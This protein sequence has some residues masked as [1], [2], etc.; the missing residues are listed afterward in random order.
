MEWFEVMKQITNAKYVMLA[1]I[2]ASLYGLSSPASKLLLEKLSPTVMASML[3]LGA[4]VGM[5]ILKII[6]RL[7]KFQNIEASLSKKEMPYI[8]GMI[9]LDILA[10]IFLMIGLTKTT[11]SNASLLNNFEI[12]VT[13]M[14][15][16]FVFKEAV[17]KRMWI[18][19]F[20]ITLSSV[21]LTFED[22]SSFTFS[23]GSVFVLLACI[24]WGFENNC[25]RMISIKDPE[26]IV[27]IKGLGSG[28]GAFFIAWISNDIKIDT[29]YAFI[30]LFLGFIAYG[31]SLLMYIAAQ[32][33]LGATRTSAYYAAAPFIGVI[34]SWIVLN[35]AVTASFLTA[36]GIMLIG[37]YFLIT[38]DHEHI[39]IHTFEIH[40]HKHSHDDSHHTHSHTSEFIGVHSH[41][42]IHEKMAH[43]HS[44]TPDVHHRHL[45]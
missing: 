33:E 36:M 16:L 24:S 21:V 28:L 40:N 25:T 34:I 4:G 17:G 35:E 22:I 15:S 5:L 42:H 20:F 39:H 9:I 26:Q 7:S 6:K 2:A 3:Y 18:A 8:I 11:S 29:A 30:A 38:E 10:P 23:I 41:E 37:T 1:I 43:K 31:I 19:I 44:H 27:V 13:A 14:I 45:H 12:V 32:R